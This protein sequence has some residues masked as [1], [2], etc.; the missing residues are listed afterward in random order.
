MKRLLLVDDEPRVLRGL[1]RSLY[2]LSEDWEIGTAEGG[3][4]ALKAMADSPYDIVVS[5]MLMPGMTGAELLNEVM[6][7]YPQTIRLVLSGHANNDLLMKCMGAVHQYLSKPCEPVVLLS[8]LEQVVHLNDHLTSTELRAF[9]TRLRRLPSKPALYSKILEALKVPDVEIE[10]IGKIVEKDIGMTSKLLNLA[11]SAFLGLGH[12]VDSASEAVTYLGVDALKALV[13][14]ARIFEQF[15]DASMGGISSND[16]WRHCNATAAAAKLIAS[17]SGANRTAADE[18]FTA[19]L[20]HDCGMLVIAGNL[21]AH[22]ADAIQQADSTHQPI[23]EIEKR[24]WGTTHAQV[25]G[26]LMGLWG[27]PIP[28]VEAITFHHAPKAHRIPA[29]SPLT[30]VHAANTL[31]SERL[32]SIHG[33]RTSPIDQSYL[34]QLG[35]G[36]DRLA[37]W[38]ELV[39]A[40]P[41]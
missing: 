18:A 39:A 1:E 34:T 6:R 24:L 14:S 13:L 21:H 31:V 16:L 12:Q 26:Y 23:A 28:I 5:D 19:G 22:Y 10:D 33:L 41:I 27:L 8:T 32:G 9:A 7:L 2:A 11:N 4:Q 15:D 36:A 40:M 38:H 29:F 37:E 17:N 20:L 30:A 3:E 25:G 35:I